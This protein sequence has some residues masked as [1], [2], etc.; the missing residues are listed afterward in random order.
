MQRV[1]PFYAKTSLAALVLIALSALPAHAQKL[2]PETYR[3][4]LAWAE[5]GK[6]NEARF[7]IDAPNDPCVVSFE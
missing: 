4:A 1:A 5:T 7:A 3:Q 2:P 6:L